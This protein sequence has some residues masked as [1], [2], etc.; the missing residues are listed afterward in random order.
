MFRLILDGKF[1][2]YAIASNR[3]RGELLPV[4]NK[5]YVIVK[6]HYTALIVKEKEEYDWKGR[7]YKVG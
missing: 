2:G 7:A 3:E 6:Q 1:I 4:K 5:E